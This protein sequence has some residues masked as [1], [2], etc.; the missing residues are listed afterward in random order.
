MR[1]TPLLILLVVMAVLAPQTA[2]AQANQDAPRAEVAGGY[3]FLRDFEIDESF[4]AG[5]FASAAVNVREMLAVVGEVSGSYATI[6][7]FGTD[8]DANVHAF[9]G[10]VRYSRRLDRVTPF[11]QFLVGV[12]R[13]GGGVDFLGVQISDSVTDFAIQPG[14]GVDVRLTDQLAARFGADYR[15]IFSQDNDG[16]EFRFAA[17]VVLGF[18]SR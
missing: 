10:G 16:N 8:I 15:R 2:S 12:A 3:V 1:R 4:P 5:W 7:L 6:N 18:G 14:G 9:M 13:A 11:G 17:G